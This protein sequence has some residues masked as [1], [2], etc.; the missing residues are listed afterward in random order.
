MKD[1]HGVSGKKQCQSSLD[2]GN[3][4][5][6]LSKCD[7]MLFPLHVFMYSREVSNG[8]TPATLVNLAFPCQTDLSHDTLNIWENGVN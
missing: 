2:V 4:C 6:P 8:Y 1:S 3:G 7:S 5:V